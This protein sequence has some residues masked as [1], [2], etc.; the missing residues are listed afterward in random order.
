MQT[1]QAEMGYFCMKQT[2]IVG[3]SS[4]IGRALVE[5]LTRSGHQV[6]VLSRS[7]DGL[8]ELDQ[9]QHYPVDI[10]AESPDFPALEGPIDGLV[11]CPGTINL[12]PFQSLKPRD[13]RHDWEVNVLGA[14][15]TLQAYQSQLQAAQ[16]AS[17][18][19]FSTVA[20]Q[21]GMPY[22]ASIASAK[23]ALEGL[24]R[25][26]AAEWAP[27]IRVNCLAPSLT[28]TPLAKR[29]LSNETR[30]EQA[31]SRHPL[32]RVGT[33][34]EV[35]ALAAFLLSEESSWI[36]GQVHHISGGIANLRT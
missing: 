34:A 23:G 4:G 35:A 11:Y 7:T 12:K 21:T 17:V 25:S 24:T 3:G 36:T 28:D 5:K 19:L 6:Q 18:V 26:L 15:K 2:I 30:V 31:K 29:L 22:H 20:V 10:T 9:V 13:F 14:V 33:A 1:T 27:G 32:K 16:Q 8:S